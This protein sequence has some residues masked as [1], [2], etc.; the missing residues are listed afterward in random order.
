[1]SWKKEPQFW[2]TDN[3]ENTEAVTA[4]IEDDVSMSVYD[5]RQMQPVLK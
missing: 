2:S 3:V 5:W 1:M 4:N